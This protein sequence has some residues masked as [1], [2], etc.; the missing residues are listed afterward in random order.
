M[1]KPF[2]Y[3]VGSTLFQAAAVVAFVL[4]AAG[5]G[6]QDRYEVGTPVRETD[7]PV[8]FGGRLDSGFTIPAETSI[9]RYGIAVQDDGVWLATSGGGF[10][11]VTADGWVLEPGFSDSR[12]VGLVADGGNAVWAVDREGNLGRRESGRW[13]IAETLAFHSSAMIVDHAGRLVMWEPRGA[14]RRGLPGQWEMLEAP[15]IEWIQ[16]ALS[17]AARPL[18]LVGEEREIRFLEG[19]V[20]RVDSLDVEDGTITACAL[21]EDG[22][23]AVFEAHESELWI[24]EGTQWTRHESNLRWGSSPSQMFWRE[25]VLHAVSGF[26]PRMSTWNGESW[27]EGPE[28]P[29]DLSAAAHVDDDP[30]GQT[31]ICSN[32]AVLRFT[33]G[34]PTLVAPAL[35]GCAGAVQLPSGEL[36]VVNSRGM[37]LILQDGV[38]TT[39]AQLA[40]APGL[41]VN[42]DRGMP[43]VVTRNGIHAVTLQGVE[44]LVL[45]DIDRPGA[46]QGDGSIVMLERGGYVS[47]WRDGALSRVGELPDPWSSSD[48]IV[49]SGHHQLVTKS[50]RLG[51]FH[52]NAMS[53]LIE[54]QGWPQLRAVDGGQGTVAVRTPSSFLLLDDEGFRDVTVYHQGPT[55][56]TPRTL[57][58]VLADGRG[59]WLAIDHDT[60]DIL[61]FGDDGWRLLEISATP[62]SRAVFRGLHGTNRLPDGRILFWDNTRVHAFEPGWLP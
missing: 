19:G 39:L 33:G 6:T 61:H 58:H 49:W 59:G 55:R 7:L 3:P 56:E 42:D 25:G 11:R 22:R 16:F 21:A 43:I 44:D 23:L 27:A 32:G 29:G 48:G 31:V 52:N 60:A 10:V 62:Y 15:G 37:V 41:T 38:W 1:A 14:V 40:A 53:V 20:W 34:T 30:D 54:A 4:F 47:I 46:Q 18:V 13:R 28:L 17:K 24:L 45:L 50:G 51:R 12:V 26:S 9:Y 35:G 36:A 5:C 57:K 2:T 8:V